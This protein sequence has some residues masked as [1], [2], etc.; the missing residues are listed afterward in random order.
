[1]PS[2]ADFVSHPES[3]PAPRPRRRRKRKLSASWLAFYGACGLILLSAI[4]AVGAFAWRRADATLADIQQDDPRLRATRT[5]PAL[6]TVTPIA[7]QAAELPTLL[8]PTMR[9]TARVEA[10]SAPAELPD[11]LRVPFTVLLIGVDKRP[12]ELEGIRSDT[13]IAVHVNPAG[14]WASM[15]SIP[16]DSVVQVPN[17][18]W[19]KINAAYAFG[20]NNA[21]AIYGAGTTP[22]EAGAAVV[23]ETVE[24]FLGISVEY[25]A[26]IDFRGFQQVVDIVGGLTIDVPAPLLDGEYPTEDYGYQRI[27]IPAGLQVMDGTTALIY[28]RTRH[29]SSDFERGKRQQA[30][31]RALL[32]QVRQ[33]GVLENAALLPEWANVLRDNIRTTLPIRDFNVLNNLALLARDLRSDRILQ[34]SINPNDVGITHED[35]SDLYWNEADLAI[36]VERWK[37]GPP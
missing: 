6:P 32:N 36:L 9:P 20:Y 17:L 5:I 12:T 10:T 7:E 19:S 3:P 23:A 31:L 24:Q 35:G 37:Q 21:E 1:M 27:Y 26:Q 28:A 16:R 4:V 11:M 2:E 18:G 25:T 33:R 14:R 8:I 22:E 29:A 13:L 34:L 15:L 30:V